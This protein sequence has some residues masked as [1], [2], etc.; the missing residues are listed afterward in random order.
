MEVLYN[1]SEKKSNTRTRNWTIVVYPDS[2]PDNWQQIL[3]DMHIEFVIS[4]LHDSDLNADGEPKKPHWHVLLLFGGVKSYEQVLE[5]VEPINCPIPKQVHNTSSLVRYM[6]HLDNPDKHQYSRS[7]I[8]VYGGAD[9]DSLLKPTSSQRYTLLA[10][11]QEFIVNQ[12]IVEFEDILEYSRVHRFNDWY[13]LLADNSTI[14]ISKFISSR[15]H[16]LSKRFD[17]ATGEELKS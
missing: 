9:L 13:P 17:F 7:D 15:R 8:Q 3:D 5:I 16:R 14:L 11:M 4:P 1:M 2:A 10:E 12:N 6:L